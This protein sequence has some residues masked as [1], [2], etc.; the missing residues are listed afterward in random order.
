MQVL[1]I[2]GTLHNMVGIAGVGLLISLSMG[3]VGFWAWQLLH[4]AGFAWSS[5]HTSCLVLLAA[6][7]FRPW[8][9]IT[10]ANSKV[11]P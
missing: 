11:C 1:C 4:L 10:V 6:T 2:I 8:A 5:M 9:F 3:F 7:A